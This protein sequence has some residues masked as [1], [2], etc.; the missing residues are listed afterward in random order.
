[1]ESTNKYLVVASDERSY[2]D[3]KNVVLELK[4]RNLPYFFLYSNSSSRL[5]PHIHLD[6]FSYDTNVEYTTITYKSKTLGFELPFKPNV[7]LITNEN[8]EPEKH[9]LWEFKQWGCFIGCIENSSWIHNSIKTK[10]EIASRKQFPSNCIDVFFDHSEWCLETKKL[11]GWWD[12]KSII[13]GNPEFD[14]L[15]L[16]GCSDKKIMIVYG[17]MEEELHPKLIKTYLNLSNKFKEW[18]VYYKPHPSELKDFP[19]DFNKIKIINSFEEY[20]NILKKSSFNI[21]LFSSVMHYPLILSKTIVFIDHSS[22][23]VN[24]ELNLEN[25]RGHEFNFWK[26]ILNFTSFDEFS[27]FI[28]TEFISSTLKRNNKIEKSI[29]KSLVPLDK[30]CTFISKRSNNMEVLE[31]FDSFNDKKASERIVNYFEHE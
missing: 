18:E 19:N 14:N 23:G 3:L 30:D 29:L 26:D 13:T 12:Q 7:L 6:N 8:W 2:L 27:T 31:Y 17:S 25:F 9:I 22:L 28:S 20:F 1:M 16:K 10:L 11:A 4:K 21:G 5:Y 24:D 15:D